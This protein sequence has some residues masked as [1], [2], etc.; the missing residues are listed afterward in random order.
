[1]P[2]SSKKRQNKIISFFEDK[3]HQIISYSIKTTRLAFFTV[4]KVAPKFAI[5][6]TGLMTTL[7]VSAITYFTLQKE[8]QTRFDHYSN[9]A[10]KNIE[11]R[12]DSYIGLLENTRTLFSLHSGT[13]HEQFRQF[14]ESL[15]IRT[16]YPGLISINYVAV[17]TP[18]RL[19]T[20]QLAVRKDNNSYRVWPDGKRDTYSSVVY[21]E[22]L[23]P[24]NARVIGFDMLTEPTR[25]AAMERARD[26]GEATLSKKLNL[27]QDQDK[28]NQSAFVLYLPLY[29]AEAPLFTVSEKR[30]AL[31][32]YI[33]S[34]FHARDL[35]KSIAGTQLDEQILNVEIFDGPISEISP[36][37]LLFNSVAQS[38]EALEKID[39]DIVGTT[40]Q[41]VSAGTT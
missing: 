28:P 20:H 23:T 9:E 18:G 26:T 21:T 7:G 12:I 38:P 15:N 11:R 24:D 5:I 3:I 40:A 10:I 41:I 4:D 39:L 35:F 33:N 6:L 16:K 37:N 13:T 34:P 32:G 30:K 19:E 31:V 25:R 1:M 27:I 8:R 22:P 2:N 29:Q 36:K 14:V 17:F